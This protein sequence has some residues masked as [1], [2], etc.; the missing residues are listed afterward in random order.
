MDPELARLIAEFDE[1]TERC[2][3][4]FGDPGSDEDRAAR[5]A[6]E[7]AER[8]LLPRL[9]GIDNPAPFSAG[10]AHQGRIYARAAGGRVIIV[11]SIQSDDGT[12]FQLALGMKGIYLRRRA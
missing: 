1:A 12:I 6:Y 10:I 3:Q 5:A 11:S 4:T 7:E 2:C 9:S 8:R